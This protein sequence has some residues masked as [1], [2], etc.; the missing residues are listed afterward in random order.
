[1][2]AWGWGGARGKGGG[3]KILH[4]PDEETVLFRGVKWGSVVCELC[5]WG[6]SVLL[7]EPLIHQKEAIV[8]CINLRIDVGEVV[9]VGDVC[10]FVVVVWQICPLNIL[11]KCKNK[12]K[13]TNKK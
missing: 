7:K 12:N 1:M 5:V 8:Y 9:L 2:W 3:L 4:V 6:V 10:L 11:N 13:Q